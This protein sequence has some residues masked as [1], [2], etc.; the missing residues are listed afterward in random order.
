MYSKELIELYMKQ[1]NYSQQKQVAADLKISK[2]YVNM[3]WLGQ[4]QLTDELG[5][6]LAIECGLDPTETV[7]KLAAA[8][9]KTPQAKNVWIDAVK[10]YCTG[11]EAA[12]CAGLTLLAACFTPTYNFALCRNMLNESEIKEIAR[13]S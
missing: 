8:R 11:A 5:I 12:A 1:K 2:S 6:Y 10:R 4:V 13:T 3:L 9:A 7:L